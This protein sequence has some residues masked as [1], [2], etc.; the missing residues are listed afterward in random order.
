MSDENE[1]A[2]S[3]PSFAPR[4]SVAQVEEG[5]RLAP[6]FDA[7]GL[8]PVVTTEAV[9]AWLD[10]G[11]PNPALAATRIRRAVEAVIAAARPGPA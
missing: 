8:I 7:A 6:R 9:I 3:G 2:G 10:A 1:S 4:A 5:N 11:R